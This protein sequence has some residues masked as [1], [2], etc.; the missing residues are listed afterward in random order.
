MD[1]F[2]YYVIMILLSTEDSIEPFVSSDI[3]LI[4][5]TWYREFKEKRALFF[6]KR[7]GP[8]S[9]NNGHNNRLDCRRSLQGST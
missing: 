1:R 5:D 4:F 2:V 3:V 9:A 6:V 7:H 8:V